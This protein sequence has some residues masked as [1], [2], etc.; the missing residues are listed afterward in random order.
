MQSFLRGAALAVSFLL[1]AVA[2]AAEGFATANVNLRSGPS[3][4]YPAVAVIP[5]GQ[6]IEIYGCLNSTAWC[7]VEV[8]RWRGWVAARYI[9]TTYRNNRV[10]LEP[11]YYRPLGIPTVT[12]EI[13]TY[14]DRYY[15]NRDFYRQRDRFDDGYRP[16]RRDW[17]RP[18][19][20]WNQDDQSWDR[21]RDWNDNDQ[22][23]DRRRRD[24]NDNDQNWDRNRP[25]RRETN[26]LDNR[27]PEER[28]RPRPD[29]QDYGNAPDVDQ[30]RQ[31]AEELERIRRVQQ[32]QQDRMLDTPGAGLDCPPDDPGCQGR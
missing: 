32:R 14:W 13:G 27:R 31:R 15:R 4:S 11:R 24:W 30:D 17:E 21:R 26:D 7:D 16:P 8:G 5:A 9:R 19:R 22:N 29:N 28:P 1:P 12:F 3:T 6:T 23:W 20:D 10:I 25:P 2:Q 18:R